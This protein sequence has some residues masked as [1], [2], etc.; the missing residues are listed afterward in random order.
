[1]KAL[2]K[3]KVGL[4]FT[5]PCN[6]G[7]K[8]HSVIL[9]KWFKTDEKKVHLYVPDHELLELTTTGGHSVPAGSK[10]IKQIPGLLVHKPIIKKK[11]GRDVPSDISS[12]TVDAGEVWKEQT[13]GSDQVCVLSFNSSSS[14]HPWGQN[15]EVDRQWLW[16]YRNFIY[17]LMLRIKGTLFKRKKKERKKIKEKKKKKHLW[18]NIFLDFRIK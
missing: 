1:M 15:T 14:W 17:V 3:I 16:T 6:S 8:G 11:Q 10:E 7:T 12:T 18:H 4:L 13:T 5:E 2:D 9:Q